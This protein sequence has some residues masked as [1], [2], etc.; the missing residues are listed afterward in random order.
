MESNKKRLVTTWIE[1][2]Y[3]YELFSQSVTAINASTNNPE[4]ITVFDYLGGKTPP[5]GIGKRIY[6]YA[7]QHNEQIESK[8]IESK[9]YSGL[10]MMYTPEFLNRWFSQENYKTTEIVE[11]SSVDDDNLPF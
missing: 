11:S 2:G 9:S 1:N 7:K 10:V 6:D 3:V 4:L 8:H 5:V